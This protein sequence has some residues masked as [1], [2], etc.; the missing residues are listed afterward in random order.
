MLI[1]LVLFHL[2]ALSTAQNCSVAP[3][4]LSI[5]NTTFS[6]GIALNR[7]I[8]TLLG[9]QLLGLRLSLSQNNTRVRN[10]RDCSEIPA[11]FSACQGASGGVF[12]ISDATFTTVPP[13][14]W[15]VS[16]VDAHPED[17]TIAFGYSAV[18][19]PGTQA[20]VNSLP[21]EVWSDRDAANKS[22]LPLGPSSSFLDQLVENSLAPNRNFGLYYGSRSQDKAIDGQLAIGG[23]DNARFKTATL[24]EFPIAGYGASSRCPLQVMLADVVLTNVE[25]NHSLFKDPDARVPA[26]IDT[27]QNAF[28][29]TKAMYQE[30]AQLTRHIDYDGSNY[31]VQVYPTDREAWI[32]S[33]T[34]KLSNGYTSVIPHYELVSKERGTDT[35]GKYSITNSSRIMAAVQTG[36]GDLGVDI[37]LLGGVFLSQNYL[38]VDYD[39]NKF[40]LAEAVVD[41]S[42]PSSIKG[43]CASKP[44]DDSIVKQDNNDIGLEIGLPVAF[45]VVALGLFG[46]WLFRRRSNSLITPPSRI[47]NPFS[48]PFSFAARAVPQQPSMDTAKHTVIDASRKGSELETIEKAREL[49]NDHDWI[50]NNNRVAELDSPPLGPQYPKN[51]QLY[52]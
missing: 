4:I 6:D 39:Q 10:S 35:Q 45:V 42:I 38:R 13:S 18:D 29:F 44:A 41:K 20:S 15:N 16:V 51:S 3:L 19:F 31:S 52:E 49:S 32:G 27:I 43:I 25:G 11:N 24:K 2:T 21:V 28:T 17:T 37:P 30:W 7:G 8:Q 36:Q 22:A 46:W 26:C 48:R 14:R 5:Q 40:W 47:Y 33:M 9:G 50:A 1:T 12:T 34:I 23:I